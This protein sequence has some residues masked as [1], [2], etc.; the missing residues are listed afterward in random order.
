MTILSSIKRWLPLP[1]VCLL[2]VGCASTAPPSAQLHTQITR[3]SSAI[4]QAEEVGAT[5]HAPGLLREAEVKFESA[6]AA[7]A[8]GEYDQAGRL[9][10]EAE[11][12]AELAGLTARSAKVKLAVD[13]LRESIRTLR[14]EISRSS[15]GQ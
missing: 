13:E 7:L 4:E 14:A 12:D 2:L 5:E 1:S 9:A 15:Q 6:Q 8:E 11:V 3:S 10:R